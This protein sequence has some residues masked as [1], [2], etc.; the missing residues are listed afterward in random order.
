MHQRA[1]KDCKRELSEDSLQNVM[2]LCL[3]AVWVT[4]LRTE[5]PI[6][7]KLQLNIL[8]LS[9][10]LHL[11]AQFITQPL[12]MPFFCRFGYSCSVKSERRRTCYLD[13]TCDP[14]PPLA[15]SVQVQVR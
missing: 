14:Y 15:L 6:P 7:E 1:I 8:D 2:S 10:P 4:L 11:H 5:N 9:A 12:W 3:I 13:A